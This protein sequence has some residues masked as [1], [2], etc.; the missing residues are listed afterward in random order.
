MYSKIVSSD[1]SSQT[2]IQWTT[3][4]HI[5]CKSMPLGRTHSRIAEPK[6]LCLWGAVTSCL[7][8]G[9]YPHQ[10]FSGIKELP[11]GVIERWLLA[12]VPHLYMALSH[13]FFSGLLTHTA[14]G[15]HLQEKH[16]SLPGSPRAYPDYLTLR[17]QSPRREEGKICLSVCLSICLSLSL[18]LI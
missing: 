4:I 11:H 1:L 10:T 6:T 16:G 2:L 18:S 7:L 3:L 13:R 15:L 14:A 17:E 8:L 5:P 9:L 12:I